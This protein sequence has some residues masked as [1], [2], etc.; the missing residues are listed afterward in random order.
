VRDYKKEIQILKEK[1]KSLEEENDWIK[2]PLYMFELIDLLLGNY[3]LLLN[4]HRIE[5]RSSLNQKACFFSID[6]KNVVCIIADERAKYIYLKKAI[7]SVE[8]KLHKT[9]KIALNENLKNIC[10]K[11]DSSKVHLAQVSKSVAVNVAYYD[12]DGEN[13]IINTKDLEF[14]ECE[15]IPISKSYIKSFKIQKEAIDSFLLLQKKLLA[16][17]Q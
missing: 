7:K 10:N 5:I 3:S 4:P 12:L 13:L 8:G 14:I 9:N 6:I 2:S 17:K 1:I 15:K 11:L 16:Y